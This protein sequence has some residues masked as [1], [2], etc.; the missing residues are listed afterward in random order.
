MRTLIAAASFALLSLSAQADHHETASARAEVYECGL[1][2]GHSLREVLDF[3]RGDFAAWADREQL[4]GMTFLWEPVAVAP[5]FDSADLRWVNYHPTWTD[6][7]KANSAW[8]SE[9]AAKLQARLFAMVDCKLPAF[10]NATIVNPSTERTEEK[11]IMLGKCSFKPDTRLSFGQLA[12]LMEERNWEALTKGDLL[13]GLWRTGIGI[14]G[15]TWD[16]L[17]MTAGSNATM[18][19]FLD[20]W[21]GKGLPRGPQAQQALPFRCEADFHRSHTVR[22]ASN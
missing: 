13:E 21:M 2:E 7:M 18:A 22:Q 1:R 20:G 3:A 6:Y 15:E 19:E 9:G 14:E 17:Q 8:R 11:L 16:F 5:P 10:A 4:A 12:T